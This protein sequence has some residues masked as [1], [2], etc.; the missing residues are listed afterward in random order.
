MWAMETHTTIRSLAAAVLVVPALALTAC[1][2]D[3]APAAD[4]EQQARDAQLAYARCMREH[5]V[6]MPDPQAGGERGLTLVAPKG[7]SPEEL[8]RAEQAC[9]KH[10]EDIEPPELTE[11]QKREF[12][13]AALAHARCMREHGVDMPDPTFGENGAARIR[14][15]KGG[16]DPNDPEVREAE[17][18]CRDKLPKG[19]RTEV[20]P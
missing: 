16:P 17:E 18:A 5:G 12:E 2:S 4:R 15:G 11:E 20:S 19:P 6:D 10:L 8:R 13:E 1:G 9:R 7:A 14:V 3:A